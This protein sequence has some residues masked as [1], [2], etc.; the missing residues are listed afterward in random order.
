[1]FNGPDLARHEP[2]SAGFGPTAHAARARSEWLRCRGSRRGRPR[3]EAAGF[4]RDRR[5]GDR[6]LGVVV[7]PAT[8][9]D[10][11][12]GQ[13]LRRGWRAHLGD[14][15]EDD[16]DGFEV[17]RTWGGRG[18][19]QFLPERSRLTAAS[20]GA[21]TGR[22][23]RRRLRC[24]GKKR[25]CP[26]SRAEEGEHGGAEMAGNGGLCGSRTC[27]TSRRRRGRGRGR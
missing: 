21:S 25:R 26:I 2:H 1:M 8:R 27:S 7:I 11:E 4:K 23:W 9:A 6:R 14:A 18:Q 24:P 16:G 15:P 19:H 10:A 13:E 3:L 5:F 12:R 20:S 17:R 22:P